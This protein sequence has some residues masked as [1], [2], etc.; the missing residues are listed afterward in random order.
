MGPFLH[1]FAC[2]MVILKALA[3]GFFP[4]YKVSKYKDWLLF[5]TYSVILAHF[6]VH[7]HLVLWS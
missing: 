5:G 4:S 7:Y 3:H 6:L 2:S 1:C